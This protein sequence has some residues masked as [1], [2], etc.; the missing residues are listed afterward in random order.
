[1]APSFLANDH[2]NV[3]IDTAS[4]SLLVLLAF[5][6]NYIGNLIFFWICFNLYTV[7]LPFSD[8][9]DVVLFV[10]ALWTI[11]IS[12]R[13]ELPGAGKV[14]QH[15]LFNSFRF[16]CQLQVV[17]IYLVSGLD[18]VASSTWLSGRAFDYVRHIGALYN[19]VFPSFLQ[20]NF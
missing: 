2:A 13:P 4:L 12:L 9:S 8:G 10:L 17:L 20:N 5:H 11:P 6:V 1:M 19:P 3:F 15:T 16:L 18:K 14:I 7:N